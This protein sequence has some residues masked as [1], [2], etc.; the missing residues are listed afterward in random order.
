M[1]STHTKVFSHFPDSALLKP[2]IAKNANNA[3]R[4][5]LLIGVLKTMS[6]S[7]FRNGATIAPS[8]HNHKQRRGSI[9]SLF[10]G[11][12]L[13]VN[14]S[15]QHGALNV[16]HGMGHGLLVSGVCNHWGVS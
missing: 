12:F 9:K 11:R 3:P 10:A 4:I 5:P 14:Y 7:V 1:I 15:S 13:A 2:T 8:G 16:C 6:P